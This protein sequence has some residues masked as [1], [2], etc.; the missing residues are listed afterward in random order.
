MAFRKIRAKKYNAILEYYN[1]NTRDKATK[2]LYLTYRDETGKATKKK[3]NTLDKDEALEISQK[4]RAEIS[5]TKKLHEDNEDN[6]RRSAHNKNLTLSQ[7]ATL[8]FD[9][10]SAKG[11]EQYRRKM[12]SRVLS[13]LGTKKASK[14]T[15]DDLKELKENLLEKGLAP[16]TINETI[17]AIRAMYNEAIRQKW[18]F[19]NPVNTK[20][21]GKIEENR[22]AGR[23][24]SD[25]ELET[26][27]DVFKNG[28][29]E[30]KLKSN[31]TLYFFSKMLYYTGARPNAVIDIQ[32]QHCD[33]NENKVKLKAMK[34]GKAYIQSIKQ[35]FMPSIK[36]WIVKHNLKHNDFL[37]YPQQTFNRSKDPK[38]KQRSSNYDGFRRSAQPYFDKLF[39]KDIPSTDKMNRVSFYSLRRTSG[40]KIYKA[41]GIV[42][43]MAF[44]N[45]TSVKTTQKYLN[46]ESDIGDAVDAL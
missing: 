20:D 43:A 14:I 4:L 25:T 7:M 13:S 34:K 35:D 15:T 45:H 32:V 31:P 28:N 17:F 38:V 18:V 37:F 21:I 27:F 1:P 3:L 26:L 16:K 5:K 40:T 23:I 39:N 22:D 9:G 42:H 46:V 2:A 10:R 11:N 44:L 41:K 24:L 36:E 33:L 30:L 29:Y 12:Q 6:I 8:Y 19:E